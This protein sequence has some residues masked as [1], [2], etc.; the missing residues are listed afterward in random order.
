[1]LAF[2]RKRHASEPIS[3]GAQ[4]LWNAGYFGKGDPTRD[5]N[6]VNP[7][8]SPQSLYR[9]HEGFLFSPGAQNFVFEAQNE[10][11]IEAIWGQAQM[12]RKFSYF[13]TQQPLQLYVQPRTFT[14]GLGGIEAGQFAFQP[15]LTGDEQGGI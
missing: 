3:T 13:R 14:N 4:E 2:L 7:F 10:L 15:L 8:A 12:V 11:P 1:M 6:E 9:Y 5:L